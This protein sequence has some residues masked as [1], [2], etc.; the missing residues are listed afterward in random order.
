MPRLFEG[1]STKR[2][3]GGG[4]HAAPG[5]G[6][7]SSQYHYASSASTPAAGLAAAAAAATATVTAVVGSRRTAVDLIDTDS[8]EEEVEVGQRGGSVDCSF[9]FDGGDEAAANGGKENGGNVVA[10]RQQPLHQQKSRQPKRIVVSDKA[11]TIGKKKNKK[12]AAAAAAAASAPAKKKRSTT[13]GTATKQSQ[14]RATGGTTSGGTGRK[15]GAATAASKKNS[16]DGGGAKAKAKTSASKRGAKSTR[17]RS[18]TR[19]RFESD[20]DRNDRGGSTSTCMTTDSNNATACTTTSSRVIP[21]LPIPPRALAV[22]T[23]TIQSF[24]GDAAGKAFLRHTLAF[25]KSCA[26]RGMLPSVLAVTTTRSSSTAR[27]TKSK[28]ATAAIGTRVVH[29]P[30]GILTG[31]EYAVGND[32]DGAGGTT[33][34]VEVNSL[35]PPEAQEEQMYWRDMLLEAALPIRGSGGAGGVPKALLAHDSWKYFAELIKSAD[36]QIQKDNA[37]ATTGAR[38][39]CHRPRT[40]TIFTNDVALF[41][42]TAVDSHKRALGRFWDTIRGSFQNGSVGSVQIAIYETGAAALVAGRKDKTSKHAKGADVSSSEGEIY[43]DD[44]GG[45]DAMEIKDAAEQERENEVAATDEALT[46]RLRVKQC[47][48]LLQ[49]EIQSLQ[50]RDR[51]RSATP[52]C[53]E[54]QIIESPIKF[55]ALLRDWI[56]AVVSPASSTGG[57]KVSFNLPETLDGSQC[58]IA[59]DLA[60]SLLPYRLD[61]IDAAK[62]MMDINS[63]SFAELEVVQ[64][65]PISSVDGSLLHGV[66]MSATAAMDSD[67]FRYKEMKVLARQLFRYMALKDVA[68]ALRCVGIGRLDDKENELAVDASL[69]SKSAA[70]TVEEGQIFLLMAEHLAEPTEQP[71]SPAN[72][73]SSVASLRGILYRY[74]TSDHLIRDHEIVDALDDDSV[75]DTAE[76]YFEYV[77]QSLQML[78]STILNPILLPSTTIVKIKEDTDA[79][80][81]FLSSDTSDADSTAEAMN[82]SREDGDD[83]KSRESDDDDFA[84]FFDDDDEDLRFFEN[85]FE[86]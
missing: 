31:R 22:D 47:I 29:V 60:P 59:L 25:L 12:P 48:A 80:D 67:L 8:S 20:E 3:P 26:R 63:L 19:V 68:L 16:S 9:D 5:G 18:P 78:D 39:P 81:E 61:S 83:V 44:G 15:S 70:A 53:V 50:E 41:S 30:T 23:R 27:A 75:D 71:L 10:G 82:K 11:K 33:R 64:V 38:S 17:K 84:S 85:D 79:P 14:A 52:I 45:D 1:S 77:E 51:R 42:D 13:T 40:L 65:V 37:A 24:E 86:Y 54:L 58:A 66:P 76:Q 28:R 69:D 55:Q 2:R 46:H 73:S 32:Y 62:L 56:H 34:G 35:L 49:R 6:S 4:A 36:G 21:T 43:D 57:G 7:A 72:L 74:A